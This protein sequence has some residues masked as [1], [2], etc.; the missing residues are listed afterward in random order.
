MDDVD[1]LARQGDSRCARAGVGPRRARGL[2]ERVGEPVHRPRPRELGDRHGARLLR[3]AHRRRTTQVRA[4]QRGCSRRGVQGVRQDQ[5]AALCAHGQLAGAARGVYAVVPR[6]ADPEPRRAA[7]R[8]ASHD[9]L[10]GAVPCEPDQPEHAGRVRRERELARGDDAG[11]LRAPLDRARVILRQYGVRRHDKIERARHPADIGE[12]RRGRYARALTAR[13]DGRDHEAGSARG[14][15]DF[16]IPGLAVHQFGDEHEALA[17]VDAR[18]LDH[19]VEPTRVRHQHE[20][21]TVGVGGP[22]PVHRQAEH[23]E[24]ALHQLPSRPGHPAVRAGGA[25]DPRGDRVGVPVQAE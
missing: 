3:A 14:R 1:A 7:V 5:P 9:P 6:A 19:R 15:Y 21:L 23:T 13:L 2:G 25:V 8:R 4:R 16:G 17:P 11:R 10:A 12:G 22:D 18:E 24:H 20:D